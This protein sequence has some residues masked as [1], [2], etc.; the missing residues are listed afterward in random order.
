MKIASKLVGMFLLALMVSCSSSS[1]NVKSPVDDLIRDLDNV[2][3]YTIILYD[4]DIEGDWSKTYKHKYKI[5]KNEDM[6]KS[7]LEALA[8]KSDDENSAI[9]KDILKEPATDS[10]LA[11]GN[12]IPVPLAQKT[13]WKPVSER[14]FNIHANDMGMEIVS[15]VDGKVTRETSPPGYS[16]Y[17]GNTRYGNWRTDSSGNSF[18][19]FYGQYAFMSNMIGLMSGPVYR[20]GYYDYHNNYRGV[21]PY[22]GSGTSTYGTFSPASKKANP[23]FHQRVSNNSTFRSRVNNSV[24]RSTT[25]RNTRSG[26]RY[27][28]G[29]SRSRSS[30]S[31]GK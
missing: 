31:G 26:S 12:T 8:S 3:D 25:A 2:Q 28:S 17:V 23:N 21:R 24:S 11:D 15:K 19:A 30:S 1:D 13:E 10:L 5:V 14:F 6:D 16:N 22:Y 18:W 9:A 29:S 4:M 7:Q 27:S 20:T